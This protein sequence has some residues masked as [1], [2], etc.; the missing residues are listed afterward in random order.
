VMIPIGP[1]P[2]RRQS[3]PWW[4]LLRLAL[5]A[6]PGYLF[7]G[8]V[9]DVD[10]RLGSYEMDGTSWVA[11]AIGALLCLGALVVVLFGRVEV[12]RVPKLAPSGP[13]AWWPGWTVAR[14]LALGFLVLL[15]AGVLRSVGWNP[16]R[17]VA[18]SPAYWLVVVALFAVGGLILLGPRPGAAPT[19]HGSAGWA[20]ERDLRR[21]GLLAS[22]RQSPEPGALLLAPYSTREHVRLPPPGAQLHALIVGPSGSGKTRGVFMPNCAAA[23]GSFVATDPK[24]ELWRETSGYH[25]RAWRFAP[26]EP[27]ASRG[28]NWIP[29]CRD[30]RLC[31]QLARAVLQL[32]ADRQ[33]EAFWTLA[34]LRLCAALFAHAA[35][36]DVPTPATAYQLLQRSPDALLGELAAS[37]VPS[38]RAA[39]AQLG[40]LRDHVR[41]GI[42]LSVADKLSFL[43]DPAVLRFT[44]A[45][46][47]APD[48][49]ELQRRP[50]GVYWILHEQDVALLQPLST[51]FFALLIDQL[52]RGR[53]EV[54][55]TLFFDEFA[56]IGPVPDFPTTISVA[57]GRG[58]ALVLGVQS[59]SQLDGLYGR[60][61]AE[62]IVTNCATKVV[63]H[64]LGH[65]SAEEVSRALG[66][67]TLPYETRS[68]RPWRGDASIPLPVEETSW[69][70]QRLAR[71]LLT[72][73]E[74]R[75]LGRD[76]A[77]VVVSN[78]R[79]I[80][81]KRW[82]W[83]RE[84][85]AA[86]SDPL[87]PPKAVGLS[88]PADPPRPD[89][90]AS[91]AS[92]PPPRPTLRDLADKL[93]RLDDELEDLDDLGR[94]PR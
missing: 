49:A 43:D 39:A 48:F 45:E 62:T 34:D 26:R 20:S 60:D 82:W 37:P 42:V 84:A 85:R 40:G 80:W 74:V 53:G 81:T 87:G 92:T 54:P 23:R 21:A 27:E 24:G 64:G 75:R 55:V 13:M 79:P 58:L 63:L 35:A 2:E 66:A 68:R 61:G 52:S 47:T 6:V 28:F 57:R 17:V 8:L 44:S 73:D 67:A 78:Q 69:S 9:L 29:L 88:R 91:P 5:A 16:F 90:S 7:V 56:N 15:V 59:L 70:E 86:P 14:W 4:W 36:L 50:I 51:L 1:A 71:P 94:E 11:A 30:E 22:T 12:H 10:R 65:R 83:N 93:K 18:W 32:E 38:A 77:V 33:E 72:A 89:S 3:S 31:R 46:L 41:A 25:A 76:E 19:S